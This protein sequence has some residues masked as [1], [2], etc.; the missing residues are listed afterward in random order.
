MPILLVSA[1]QHIPV[2]VELGPRAEVALVRQEQVEDE[3]RVESPVSGIVEDEDGVDFQAVGQ[4]GRAVGVVDGFAEPTGM[5]GVVGSE[6]ACEGPDGRAGVDDVG[7]RDDV[8][9]AVSV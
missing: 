5:L 2:T 3:S 1:V 6:I 8:H 7:G 4:G 9:E